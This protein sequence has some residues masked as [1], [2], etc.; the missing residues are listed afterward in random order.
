LIGKTSSGKDTVARYI[1]DAYG[2]NQVVSYTTRPKRPCE[3]NGVEHIR[4]NCIELGIDINAFYTFM[5]YMIETD[6][7]MSNT[8]R[9]MNNIALLRDTYTGFAPIYDTGNSMFFRERSLP[10]VVPRL[11]THSFVEKELDLLKCIPNEY[12]C[13]VNINKLPTKEEFM[14]IY[15]QDVPDRLNR[16]EPLYNLYTQKIA[17]LQAFQ[18]GKDIWRTR[19]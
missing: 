5:R 7:I 15:S 8:D 2:I 12:R 11:K 13:I 10:I 1:K 17:L 3:T 4:D 14:Q 9:Y 16:L 6:F 19:Y 18:T